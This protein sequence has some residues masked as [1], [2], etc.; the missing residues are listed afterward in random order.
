MDIREVHF[1]NNGKDNRPLLLKRMKVPKAPQVLQPGQVDKE[2]PY[3]TVHDFQPGCL[4]YAFSRE[5]F[6]L[7]V[8]AFTQDYF[9]QNFGK[10][11][12]L[13]E[14]EEPRVPDATGIIIPPYN[15]FG[16]EV[17][18]LGYVYKLEPKKPKRD[19]FK[20]VDN[21]GKILRF[22]ARFN[23]QVPED[24]D[25]RFII[26]Y[27]LADDT[28]SI[29]EPAQKNSGIV[30]GKFLERNKYKNRWNSENFLTPND[31]SIGGDVLI[32]SYSFHVLSA[33][34]YTAKYLEGHYDE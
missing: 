32:N 2:Q 20:Y 3:W 9:M 29:F 31:I 27:Y 8:D 25:R 13:G 21:D 18:S 12:N 22:T 23:T 11:F 5:F 17:D 24:V 1:A 34:E 7:G 6:I 26:S 14:N 4:V 15:G 10:R 28:I 30:E 16:D 19:F 33:D